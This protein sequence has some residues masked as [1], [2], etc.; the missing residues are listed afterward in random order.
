MKVSIAWAPKFAPFR[1]VT[2]ADVPFLEVSIFP[3][4]LIL[5]SY[6]FHTHHDT[7]PTDNYFFFLGLLY[8]AALRLLLL[9][10]HPLESHSTPICHHDPGQAQEDR[11]QCTYQLSSGSLYAILISRCRR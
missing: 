5:I 10:I 2:T 1:H 11:H 7:W 3:T 4:P 9:P 8:A 6:F